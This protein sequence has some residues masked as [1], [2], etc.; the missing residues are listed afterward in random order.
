MKKVTIVILNYKTWPKVLDCL[1]SLWEL[2]Y[3]NVE[4]VVVDNH[5]ENDSLAHVHEWLEKE[6]R[7]HIQLSEHEIQACAD[8]P[9]SLLLLQSSTNGGYAAGNNLGIQVGLARGAEYV[10]ILNSDTMVD[11]R[12]LEPLVEYGEA[13]ESVGAVGPKLV[14]QNGTPHRTCARRRPLASEYFFRLGIGRYLFP[15]NRWIRR[16]YY[17]DEYAFERPKKVDILSGACLMIKSCVFQKIGLLDE[18]TFLFLEEFILAEKLRRIGLA[19]A[20]VPASVVF[21][22][23]GAS[24]LTR[25]ACLMRRVELSSQRYY[26]SEYRRFGRFNVALMMAASMTPRDLLLLVRSIR[27]SHK[28]APRLKESEPV[29]AQRTRQY[30]RIAV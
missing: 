9:G 12:F 20:V 8:L 13:H 25:Q 6:G 30:L 4:I 23:G 7:A 24:I 28:Q 2:T 22:E 10:L 16:H 15:N 5:S 1:R 19:S 29:S 17:Q 14:K 26:L 18:N 3:A 21:H 27:T 11:K